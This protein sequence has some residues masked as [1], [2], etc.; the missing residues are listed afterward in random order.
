MR[1]LQRFPVNKYDG[2]E[3]QHFLQLHIHT[4]LLPPSLHPSIPKTGCQRL[5][6]KGLTFREKGM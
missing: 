3:E 6:T 2:A 4:W 5:Q 1:R